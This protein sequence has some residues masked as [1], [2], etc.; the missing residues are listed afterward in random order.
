[1]MK[2]LSTTKDAEDTEDKAG[3]MTLRVLG[4]LRGGAFW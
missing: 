1:M 4:V 2:D 3:L